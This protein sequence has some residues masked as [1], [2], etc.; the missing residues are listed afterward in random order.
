[1][2]N[3]PHSAFDG[4]DAQ[5]DAAIRELQEEIRVNPVTVPPRPTYPNKAFK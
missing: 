5:L 2:D 1:V 4:E 3:L